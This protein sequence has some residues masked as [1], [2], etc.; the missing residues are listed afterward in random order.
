M[1]QINI[2]KYIRSTIV[3]IV[4]VVLSFLI[5]TE[6]AERGANAMIIVAAIVSFL[7]L[8]YLGRSAW[9]TLFLL[10]P[11]IGMLPLGIVQRL[12]LE[13][14]LAVPICAYWGIMC[15][16]RKARF[17]WRSVWW[18]DLATLILFGYFAFTYLRHPVSVNVLSQGEAKTVGGKDYIMAC[19]ALAYYIVISSI[20]YK[21]E[22]LKKVLK[23]LMYCTLFFAFFFF[24]LDVLRGRTNIAAMNEAAETE[25]MGGYA[26]LGGPLFTYLLSRYK[27]TELVFSVRNAFL[28]LISVVAVLMGGFREAL[29]DMV[30]A[31]MAA[32]FFRKQFLFFLSVCAAVYGILVYCGTQDL[33]ES[34]PFGV[35]R[36][37]SMFPGVKVSKAAKDSAEG[38]AEWRVVMWR[39][40]MD[41]RTGYIK[42]YVWGDGY[43]QDMAKLRRWW[44]GVQRGTVTFGEQEYFAETGTWHSGPISTIH[45]TGYVGLGV[46]TFW[47]LTGLALVLFIGRRIANMK[48]STALYYI[49]LSFPGHITLFYISAR[50][51]ASTFVALKFA[52]MAKVA[53]V[54]ALRAGEIAPFRWRHHYTPM[55]L[56]QIEQ[57]AADKQ[58]AARIQ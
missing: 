16:V 51:Y 44:T 56:Q 30:S 42:D 17:E 5:G 39:W 2:R 11:L 7:F 14:T 32:A 34:W 21:W 40:A 55:T 50:S 15:L 45:R 18:F 25:R 58:I 31:T 33:T 38:S 13:Y 27:I 49:I 41:P 6:A 36:V 20:P 9:W 1:E 28:C 43:G 19:F 57:E 48:D 12:P 29:L 23:I 35:Q 22:P 46:V 10:P 26:G 47:L 54:E 4:L 8:M 3:G 37:A 53:Y 52:V 24:A